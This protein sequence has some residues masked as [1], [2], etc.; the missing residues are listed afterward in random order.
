MFDIG[1]ASVTVNMSGIT[2]SNG[3][4][5]T[6]DVPGGAL[7]SGGAIY[8]L[9]TLIMNNCAL[10]G[11]SATASGITNLGGAIYSGRTLTL[12][13]CILNSNAAGASLPDTAGYGGAIYSDGTL[14]MTNCTLTGNSAIGASTANNHATLA[15]GGAIYNSNIYLG[16]ATLTNCTISGNSAAI[17]GGSNFADGGGI[18]QLAE[19]AP[20]MRNTIV[21]GNT[22]TVSGGGS[23]SA[24]D[25]LGTVNSLGH[26]VIGNTNNS[27]GWVASDKTNAAAMP[28]N[29]A[30]LQYFNSKTKVLPL[31]VGSVAIDAGDDSVTGPPLNITSDQRGFPRPAGAHVDIGAFEFDPTFTVTVPFDADDG[32]CDASCTLREA[33]NAANASP[34]DSPITF[35]PYAYPSIVL[36]GALPNLSTEYEH[37]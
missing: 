12:T 3:H 11:N 10:S 30:Q 37:N 18:T 8:N 36:N 7:C 31:L 34:D 4:L 32:A 22:V 14:N 33:I 24:P 19:N 23:A 6:P 16:P 17:S 5:N 1:L 9:G 21:A 35:S 15:S 20:S 27:F 29:L 2:I 26:N 28:L 13:N 25:V